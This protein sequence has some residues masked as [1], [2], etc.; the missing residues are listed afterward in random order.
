MQVVAV[1]GISGSGSDELELG[2]EKRDE[3]QRDDSILCCLIVYSRATAIEIKKQLWTA[4]PQGEG[5]RY[6]VGTESAEAW[7]AKAHRGKN[8][9]HQNK[10]S[11]RSVYVRSK[12]HDLLAFMPTASMQINR[13]R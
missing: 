9:S 2:E 1:V 4:D 8:P 6:V 13:F 10:T 12:I 7:W 3:E 11:L 5:K